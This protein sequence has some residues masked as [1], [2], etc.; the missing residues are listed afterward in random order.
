MMAL[1]HPE[2]IIDS[3]ENPLTLVK[4]TWGSP[5]IYRAEMAEYGT[6]SPEHYC[7]GEL[8]N[9]SKLHY[10]LTIVAPQK[11]LVPAKL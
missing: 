11:I 4:T 9:K 7:S 8:P 6:L 5:L 3:E 1:Q 10:I 2:R